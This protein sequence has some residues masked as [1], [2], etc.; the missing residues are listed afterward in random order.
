ML[1]GDLEKEG[2]AELIEKQPAATLDVDAM[3]VGHHGSYNATTDALLQRLTPEV[4]VIEMGPASRQVTWSAYAYG[5]PRREAIDLLMKYIKQPRQSEPIK[6]LVGVAHEE[7]I[8]QEIPVAIYGT[9]WD[10][11]VILEA[12]TNGS[13]RAIVHGLTSEPVPPTLDPHQRAE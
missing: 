11:T 5:H 8:E 2:I 1:M 6:V 4:A 10:G 9:G 7:F 13:I 3:K 12:D